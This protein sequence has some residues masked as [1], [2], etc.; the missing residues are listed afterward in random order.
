MVKGGCWRAH[1]S[2]VA[3]LG[4]RP[5]QAL[6]V[7]VLRPQTGAPSSARLSRARQGLGL[8]DGASLARL[9]KARHRLTAASA[10]GGH[11]GQSRA[12]S[13]HFPHQPACQGQAFCLGRRRQQSVVADALEAR[14]QHMAQ[15]SGDE[16]AALQRH[17]P[18][19]ARVAVA[20]QGAGGRAAAI[21]DMV[22]GVFLCA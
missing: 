3:M 16:F 18:L 9:R 20:G 6:L 12:V 11:C 5:G 14:R 2:A 21:I 10:G 8:R 4:A 13:G 17:D 15:Q 7:G 1:A 19:A 22:F